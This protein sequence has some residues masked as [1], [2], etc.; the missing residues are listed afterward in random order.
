MTSSA[1][2]RLR[3]DFHHI[4]VHFKKSQVILT[5]I[6]EHPLQLKAKTELLVFPANPTLQHDFTIQIGSWCNFRWPD[7]FQRPIFCKNCSI[8]LVCNAQHAAQLLV[9]ALV[10]FR[11]DYCNALLAG[12]PSCTIH[13]LQMIQNAGLVF[14]KLKMAHVTLLF[15]SLH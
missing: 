7:D 6:K 4:R 12:L 10:I 9:Q 1:T 3:L 5:W 15:I 11:L 13:F 14:R 8:L 2:S